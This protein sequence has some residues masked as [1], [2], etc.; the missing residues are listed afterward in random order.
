MG[1]VRRDRVGGLGAY[2]VVSWVCVAWW[3]LRGPGSVRD[4]VGVG[5]VSSVCGED[6]LGQGGGPGGCCLFW[7]GFS[8]CVGVSGPGL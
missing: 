1:D 5:V 4:W 7:L 6:G 3:R 8:G 2:F